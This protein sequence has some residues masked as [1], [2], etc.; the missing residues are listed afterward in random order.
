MLYQGVIQTHLF[1][2][3]LAG[4]N[5]KVFTELTN[6]YGKVFYN[7]KKSGFH[8]D[9]PVEDE[10]T[11]ELTVPGSYK[12]TSLILCMVTIRCYTCIDLYFNS[13]NASKQ[14]QVGDATLTNVLQMLYQL[15]LFVC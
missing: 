5:Q 10:E 2:T 14:S 8:G 13:L 12:K 1:S 15:T 11:G 4:K 7:W 6:E 9:I 3:I